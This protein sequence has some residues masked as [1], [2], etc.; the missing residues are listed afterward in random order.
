MIGL[1]DATVFHA[2]TQPR[3]NKFRYGAFYIVAPVDELSRPR[4]VGLF[5]VDRANVFGLRTRDYGDGVTSPAAW[6]RIVLSSW[7][8]NEADG[9][10][11]LMTLPRMF[12]YAFN[13]VSF[14]LCHD[15]EGG[16][17]AV[18]AEV[19][20]TFGERHSY[21]CYHD[22]HRAIAADDVLTSRK[23]FHV[24]PFM[25]MEGAYRFRFSAGQERMAVAI[26]LVDGCETLLRTSVTGRVA[27]LTSARL[28]RAVLTNPLY[29]LKVIG[30]IHYQA[31]KLF[32]KGLR[33]FHKPEPPS[34]TISR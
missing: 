3:A 18:L 17:R 12:G 31:V 32:L 33:H 10:V 5:S 9:E 28:L 13:P 30:L 15:K 23:V 29:P 21:L 8:L 14:W 25:K 22:D 7:H 1:L 11:R 20:N 24:S 26:D 2:R 19:R 27:Q 34:V 16:L 4:R 6:I